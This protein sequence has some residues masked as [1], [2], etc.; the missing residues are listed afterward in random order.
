MFGE[1][2]AKRKISGILGRRTERIGL[3]INMEPFY[4]VVMQALVA[5]LAY[6]LWRRSRPRLGLNRLRPVEFARY[7][8]RRGAEALCLGA[9]GLGANGALL[10]WAA[11]TGRLSVGVAFLASV[12]A[13]MVLALALRSCCGWLRAL[14][15]QHGAAGPAERLAATRTSRLPVVATFEGRHAQPQNSDLAPVDSRG[16][17]SSALPIPALA[18]TVCDDVVYESTLPTIALQEPTFRPLSTAKGR[19]IGQDKA[20]VEIEQDLELACLGLTRRADRPLASFIF[21][22]ESG[23]GKTQTAHTI[24]EVLYGDA[25]RVAEFSMNEAQGEGGAWRAFGP[26][27]GYKDAE[28]GGE[29][30][31]KIKRFGGFC[32]VLLDEI[33]KGPTEVFDVLLSALD[34]GY[35]QDTSSGEAIS[36]TRCVVVMTTNAIGHHDVLSG[37][38]EE[39]LRRQ[40]RHFRRDGKSV[41]RQEFLNRVRRVVA[42]EPLS[43]EALQEIAQARYRLFY[44]DNVRERLGRWVDGFS[45]ALCQWL[46]KRAGS[47]E[48]WVRRLDLLIERHIVSCA[49]QVSFPDAP[50]EDHYCWDLVQEADLTKIR[51][52]RTAALDVAAS[53]QRLGGARLVGA[54]GVISQ[55]GNK[56]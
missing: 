11:R 10:H 4:L 44:A 32:V 49:K 21:T 48:G 13:V 36:I 37:L 17:P 41:F 35:V 23:V 16:P 1:K 3:E 22:G 8:R 5:S 39:E 33:E 31:V 55:P 34:K 26:P 18:I 25:G 14:R 27:P 7:R 15:F 47:G 52:V 24:A 30:T 28:R 9:V 6:T 54:R 40:L 53:A 12:V 51:L 56:L 50:T 45:P 46:A 19:I 38:T 20:V 2:L 29:L 42:F 43:D